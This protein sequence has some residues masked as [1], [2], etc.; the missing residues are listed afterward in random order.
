MFRLIWT[1]KDLKNRINDIERRLALLECRDV[2]QY[3]DKKPKKAKT[4]VLL[5][6]DT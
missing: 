4:I 6:Q 1:V 3:V 5:N 2:V